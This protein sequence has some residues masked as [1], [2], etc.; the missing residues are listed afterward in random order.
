MICRIHCLFYRYIEVSVLKVTW[1]RGPNIVSHDSVPCQRNSVML[2]M[3]SS[4]PSMRQKSYV[5][6]NLLIPLR[7]FAS[8]SLIVSGVLYTL[9]IILMRP[10][11]RHKHPFLEQMFSKNNMIGC[12][13]YSALDLVDGYYQ[14]L[15]RASDI[16]ITEVSTPIN[17]L[18]EWLVLPQGIS[19]APAT[20]IVWWRNGSAL[21]VQM[22][23]RTL[24]THLFR[25]V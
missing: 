2:L 17:M 15:M 16:P 23:N 24:M 19:N 20:F 5:R 12:T 3:T 11:Y 1:S 9:I 14:L 4:V 18:W 13:M 6:V 7:K 10:L 22:H 21:T 8:K 25:A